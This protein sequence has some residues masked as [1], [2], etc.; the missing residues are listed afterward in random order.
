[1]VRMLPNKSL[2]GLSEQR[3]ARGSPLN[4]GDERVRFKTTRE[5]ENDP[6]EESILCR[7][8]RCS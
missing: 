2:G 5:S 7:F 6:E 8:D 4:R 3:G 1:M